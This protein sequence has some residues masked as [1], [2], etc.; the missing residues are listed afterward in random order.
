MYF[1]TLLCTAKAAGIWTFLLDAQMGILKCW[2][3]PLFR[4]NRE[5]LKSECSFSG[6]CV[7]HRQPLPKF[8]N[9]NYSTCC[10]G[11]LFC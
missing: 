5:E 2:S 8:A 4:K 6:L 10:D 7:N 11:A 3:E 1:R 9:S